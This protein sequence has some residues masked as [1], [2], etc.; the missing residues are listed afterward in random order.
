MLKSDDRNRGINVI[1]LEYGL[2]DELVESPLTS[3]I[4]LDLG[5]GNGD[6]A[7][8]LAARYPERTVLAAD[9]M[10]GRLRKVRNHRDRRGLDNL[11]ILR[12]EARQLSRL[13][14][15]DGFF[16]RIHVLCPDPWPKERH[17]G[18]RLISSEF[19]GELNRVLRFRGVFHFSSDDQRYFGTVVELLERS[20]LFRR[21]D[22]AIDD[23]RD[24]ETRFQLRWL[25]LGRD[26]S[27]GAWMKN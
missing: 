13:M 17:R 20:G 26:V 25:E 11:V 2:L 18:N 10:I 16:D 21:D 7:L 5:C 12:A 14:S 8:G 19:I 1:N 24:I 27:R 3:P 6:L 9:V 23:I 22:S 4:E 15:R